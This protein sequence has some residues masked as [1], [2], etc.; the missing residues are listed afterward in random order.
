MLHNQ[1]VSLEA[2]SLFP[3]HDFVSSVATPCGPCVPLLSH[4]VRQGRHTYVKRCPRSALQKAPCFGSD[5]PSAPTERSGTAT[6]I[7]SWRGRTSGC[8]AVRAV[9]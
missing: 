4:W 7:A 8:P 3:E 2:G 6:R 9:C 1:G 5:V